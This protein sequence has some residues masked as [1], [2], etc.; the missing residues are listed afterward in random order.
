MLVCISTA[1]GVTG[2]YIIHHQHPALFQSKARLLIRYVMDRSGPEPHA[3]TPNPPQINGDRVILTEIEIL[4]S[5]DLSRQVATKLNPKILSANPGIP[6][7]PNRAAD[8]ILSNLEVTTGPA[9][10]TLHLS[11]GDPVPETAKK[12]LTAYIE[13][14]FSRHLEIH[15]STT[16]FDMVAEQA[17]IAESQ[18][19]ETEKQLNRLRMDAG[20]M[21]LTDATS[22]LSSQRSRTHEELMKAK[23][24]CAEQNAKIKALEPLETV[25]AISVGENSGQSNP[26][27]T[28]PPPDIVSEYRSIAELIPF[29]R[30]RDL[31]LRLKFKLNNRTILHNQEQ[32]QSYEARQRTLLSQFPILDSLGD[33]QNSD[34]YPQWNLIMERAKLAANQAKISIYQTNLEELASE[35]SLQYAIGTQIDELNRKKIMQDEE[36]RSLDSNLRQAKLDLSLDPSRMPNIT[37]IETPTD[38]IKTIDAKTK[39]WMLASAGSGLALGILIAIIMETRNDRRIRYPSDVGNQL[40]L[41]IAIKIP[42]ISKSIRKNRLLSIRNVAQNLV[43]SPNVNH[44]SS[45]HQA[46]PTNDTKHLPHFILPY[47]DKLRDYIILNFKLKQNSRRPK[48]IALIGINHGTGTST[49]AA[50]LAKS[51]TAIPNAKVLLVDLSAKQPEESPLFAQI[52]RHTLQAAI[53]ISKKL[54]FQHSPQ[55]L[56][57]ANP[58]SNHPNNFQDHSPLHWIDLL[59]E[60][61]QSSYDYVIFDLPVTDSMNLNILPIRLMDQALLVIDA[62]NSRHNNLLHA[63]SQLQN[64]EAEVACVFNKS[65]SD[66]PACLRESP[67]QYTA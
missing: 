51:L 55:D 25:Q 6:H 33:A 28:S 17:S 31:E 13:G 49:V 2:S 43:A 35:F 63:I 21:N 38:A 37:L 20:L 53:G 19:Q 60:L 67:L 4:T 40:K 66:L 58:R 59:P 26:I 48:L 62:S 1:I 24:E 18:L 16:A 9:G 54:T 10:N 46:T 7:D 5:K 29:L 56:F 27:N 3:N 15:R 23:A 65:R 45:E 11:Y 41:P 61:R 14:Y 50:G 52:P 47:T 57:Y 39:K 64:C 36:F 42:W 30:K 44:T 12:I 8:T 22:A 34:S 32:L